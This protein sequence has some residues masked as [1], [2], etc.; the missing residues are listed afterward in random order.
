MV[1]SGQLGTVAPMRRAAETL[2]FGFLCVV[3]A[4]F[5]VACVFGAI[6][7]IRARTPHFSALEI[8]IGA[9][10]SLALWFLGTRLVGELW[11]R[12]EQISDLRGHQ[13]DAIARA[14]EF[15]SLEAF[16]AR[17]TEDQEERV[18][19]LRSAVAEREELIDELRG[20]VAELQRHGLRR[21]A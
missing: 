14:E 21:T 19:R 7:I 13:A 11:N 8:L 2:W 1:P 17:Q 5:S 3:W 10:G 20:Q 6:E 16:Y 12:G 9:A 18:H 4:L 15:E